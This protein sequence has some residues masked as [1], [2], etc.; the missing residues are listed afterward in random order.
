MEEIGRYEQATK[1]DLVQIIQDQQRTILELSQTIVELRKEIEELKHPVRKDSTNSSIPSSKEQIPRTRS[2]RKKSGKKAGG[3]PGHKGHQRERHPHPDKTVIVQASHCSNC[4]SSLADVEG[5]IG[6]I[7]QE[8][9]IPPIT[10]LI[11]EYQQVLKVCACGHCNRPVLP[12]SGPVTIGPQMTALITYFNV[13][14]GLPYGRLTQ[15][16]EDVLGFAIS[17]GTVA[18]KLKN[19]LAQTKGIIQQIKAHILASAWT[20]SDETGTHVGGKLFWQWVW[21]SPEASYY[22]VDQRRGYQVVKEYFTESYHG[23]LIHDCWSAQNNTQA[24][25]H[26]L[27]HAHLVRNLQYAIDKERSV[28]AYR[29]QRL[30]LK[31]QRARQA[32]WQEGAAA[33]KRQ[34]VIQFYQDQFAKLLEMPLIHKEE[35]RLQK[36]LIKHQDWIFTFMSYSDVPPDNNSSERAIKAAK[37]KDKVSGG[38]RSESG[39]SRFAQLLSLTQT[40]RKQHLPI[41]AS[42]RAVLGGKIFLSSLPPHE[43]SLPNMACI[44]SD[45]VD[46]SHRVFQ[47][48]FLLPLSSHIGF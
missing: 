37:L 20:G 3:Q 21:Q 34:A 17:E 30:L 24:S 10:P 12:I 7:A 6:Q 19:M 15:I 39:A 31:S 33:E 1:E 18:N 40:L 23:V 14:H 36:R 38:F 46:R 4:G 16:T 25:A 28:F 9:D 47:C 45:P 5:T 41:L 29:V 44:R 35:N 26:Q 11:T 2:Q 27:C 42:L 22:V 13:E 43:T 8:I 48:V 32:I